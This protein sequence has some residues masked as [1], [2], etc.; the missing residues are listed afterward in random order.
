METGQVQVGTSISIL[1]MLVAP[2]SRSKRW[3]LLL[4]SANNFSKTKIMMDSSVWL[5]A[6]SILVSPVVYPEACVTDLRTVK[7]KQQT[8]FFDTAIAE[9]VLSENVFTVDLKK[10]APGTYD[11]GFIDGSKHTGNITYTSVSTANGFWEFTGTGYKVGSGSFK[12]ASIDAIADTGTTLLLLDDDIV[13]DY[14]DQVDG[15]QY[16]NSQGGYTFSCDADLP[17]F[18]VGI[19]DY[20]AVIPGSYLN[21]AAVDNSGSC[22]SI[23]L[24]ILII[25]M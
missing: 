25:V 23:L 13:S 17:D 20:H 7:P 9:G 8:T 18:A 14:Y 4:K 19:E 2:P 15:A 10:G 16:D 1:S 21:Y 3:N 6:L 12:T 11:F 5:S 22:K 24:C